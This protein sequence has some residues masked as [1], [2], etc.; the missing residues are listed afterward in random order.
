M[1]VMEEFRLLA[2]VKGVSETDSRRL[3]VWTM[4]NEDDKSKAIV[5]S[6]AYARTLE[7]YFG[8]SVFKRMGLGENNEVSF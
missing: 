5:P 2:N 1:M 7:D 3:V 6:S 8:A 4:L